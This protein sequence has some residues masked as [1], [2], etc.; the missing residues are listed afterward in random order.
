MLDLQAFAKNKKSLSKAK[1]G[2]EKL[3]RLGL[4]VLTRGDI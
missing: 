4:D 2:Y 1:K 3:N